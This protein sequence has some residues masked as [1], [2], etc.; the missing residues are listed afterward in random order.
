[1]ITT[2]YASA[3]RRSCRLGLLGYCSVNRRLFRIVQSE[4]DRLHEQLGIK[5]SVTVISDPFYGIVHNETGLCFSDVEQSLRQLGTFAAL[6]NANHLMDH[7][8]MLESQFVDMVSDTRL[9]T[10][11]GKPHSEDIFYRFAVAEGKEIITPS[12]FYQTLI[13]MLRR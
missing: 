3:T 5:L 9:P 7:Y 2:L 8:W 1:M 13:E 12:A 4:G 10:V 6:P 11:D